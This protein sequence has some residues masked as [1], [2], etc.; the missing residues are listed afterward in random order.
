MQESRAK[1]TNRR[2]LLLLE[3]LRLSGYILAPAEPDRSALAD[4][5]IRRM[6]RRLNLS[7]ADAE[8]WLGML[9]QIIWK[10][11]AGSPESP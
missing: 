10:M 2:T 4:E 8:A 11:G 7:T 6:V 5:K 9:R 3:A 1:P